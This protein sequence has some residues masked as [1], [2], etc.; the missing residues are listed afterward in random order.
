MGKPFENYRGLI[1]DYD[2]FVSAVGRPLP[3]HI[4][5]NELR[6]EPDDALKDLKEKGVLF[7]KSVPDDNTLF[8]ASNLTSPGNLMEYFLGHIHPQALTSCLVPLVLSPLPDSFVLDMCASPGGKTSQ[9]AQKMGNTGVIVANELYP[10]RHI[11]LAHTLARLGVMN[12]V[13]TAY[14]AQEF[15]LREPFD[16]VLADVPCSG[17]GRFRLSGKMPFYKGAR[18][19]AKLPELQKR[20][21]L[22][23]FD[24]LKEGG[25]MVYATCTYNPG[26]NEAVVDF[27]LKNR[28]AEM[29]PIQLGLPCE[30]GITEWKKEHYE[31][32]LS[33]SVRFY[34]HQLDSVGFFMAKIGRGK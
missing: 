28:E 29:L 14:Q 31:K 23:G 24:L 27:L 12:T 7:Q 30:P 11:P 25:V 2:A 22:R 33:R 6:I 1:P 9:M 32:E 15:P 26:E 16:L 19:N 10:D 13:Q 17:E 8:T 4:R 21:I 18:E 5:I 20:I 34:P 3:V